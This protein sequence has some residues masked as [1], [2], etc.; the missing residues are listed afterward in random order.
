MPA[1]R[2]AGATTLAFTILLPLAVTVE[3]RAQSPTIEFESR[4]KADPAPTAPLPLVDRKSLVAPIS[5][6]DSVIIKSF[7]FSGAHL[8]PAETLAAELTSFTGRELSAADLQRAALEI[9]GSYLRRGGMARVRVAAVSRA[10]G[11]AEIEIRELRIGRLRVELPTETRIPTELVARFVTDG[12]E[13]GAPVPLARLE[14]G[15]ALLNAQPGI[16]AAIAIDAGAKPD[17]VD[18]AVSVRDRPVFSGRIMLDNHGL[19]EIGQDRLGLT[20]NANN[21]FGLAERLSL[22]LEQTAG[23]DLLAPA[24]SVAL[25]NPNLR[26][27][28]EATVAHYEARRGG[29]AIELKGDFLHGR[30]FLQHRWRYASGVA[31][32]AEYA[33]WRTAYRDD[34][35]FGELR[36]RRISGVGVNFSGVARNGGGLTR[37]GFDVD[38]GR[39]D[40]SANAGDFA[41]DAAS[42]KV[43]GGFWRLRW[44]LG[45]E[46]AYGAGRLALRA[47]GQWTD[48]NL[49]STQQFALG[50]AIQVRAYPTAE[51]LGDGGWIAAAEWRQ[52]VA[53]DVDGRLFVDSGSIKRNAKPWVDQRNRFD[54]S[55]IGAGLDWRLPE[56][57]R[58]AADLA[59][60]TGGNPGRNPDGTD[61]DGRD[62]RWRLW[63][64]LR[65]DF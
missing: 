64:S 14:D 18:I 65:R 2:L 51:A 60:Q 10:E 43:D 28:F 21:A 7:R 24:F 3:A 12:L 61:S 39:A 31:L 46:F 32:N 20:L 15:I 53:A 8:I 57:F 30:V 11:I 48:R 23:S 54:L 62:T 50:G 27:G 29:A 33:V 25:P 17:E 22:G 42:A 37:F 16:A 4:Q 35:L 47:N 59:R 5:G 45:H 38:H 63:L 58:F 1:R 26:L 55:G 36:R 56:N 34:S 49:D 13:A 41:L 19:R 44:N 40:L 6:V 9:A 52:A